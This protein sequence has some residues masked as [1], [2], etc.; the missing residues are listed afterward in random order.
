[1]PLQNIAFIP[2]GQERDFGG[3]ALLVRPAGE[4]ASVIASIR[5][6]IRGFYPDANYINVDRLSASLD[7]QIRPW[8]LG[9]TMFSMCGVLALLVAAV[10]L[11]SVMSYSVA[12]RAHEFA[13]RTALGAQPMDI[14]RLIM[15]SGLGLA[16]TGVALGLTLAMAVG[17]AAQPLLFDTSAKPRSLLSGSVRVTVTRARGSL[18]LLHSPPAMAAVGGVSESRFRPTTTGS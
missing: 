14:V 11:Y 18:E 12:Q 4:V 5:G 1:M 8:R 16:L 15:T 13:V 7:P 2:F 6:V 9:A 10:G 17:G 3:T